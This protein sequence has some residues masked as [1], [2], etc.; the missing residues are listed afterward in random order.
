MTV[1]ILTVVG[2]RP[3]FIKAA[4]VSRAIAAVNRLEDDA[5]LEEIVLH[6]GQHYDDQM[7]AVFFEE[8]E[9]SRPKYNLDVG[10]GRHGAQTAA[11]LD[12]LEP[13]LLDEAPDVVLVYGDTNSTLAGAIAAAKAPVQVAHVEA[14]LRSFRRDMPE[15]VNRVV[16]DH[17]ATLLFAPSALAVENLRR[18]GIVEGVHEVGD[19]M[20]DVLRWTVARAPSAESV[21]A[22]FGVAGPYAV[23]TVHRAENTDAGDRLDDI[24]SGLRRVAET[25]VDVVVPLHPRTRQR[26][27]GRTPAAVHVI[28]P[29]GHAELVAL[30]M[31]STVVLTDSGGLQKEAYWLGVPCVTLRNET[32]WPETVDAGWNIAVGTEPEAIVSAA[33]RPPP[34]ARPPLYGDGRTG[35]AIVDVLRRLDE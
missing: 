3:Q 11:I 32:E 23:A 20:Y 15:E 6:T 7:S 12:R 27:Q 19:V 25:G 13:V 8:L 10:S 17:I 16:C 21:A 29:L 34:L 24:F 9:L 18:E 22:R 2:A 4:G 14:G 35:S 28:E 33:L 26:L 5:V 30:M 1:R 31:G